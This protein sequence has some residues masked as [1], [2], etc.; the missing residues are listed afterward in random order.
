MIRQCSFFSIGTNDLVQYTLAVDRTNE[1]VASYYVP[2]NPSVLRLI[3]TAARSAREAGKLCAVC[4]ELAGD[5]LF[6][7]FFVGAGIT[8]L[9][10]EAQLIP[11]IKKVIR[12]MTWSESRALSERVLSCSRAGDIRRR[13]AKFNESL[14]MKAD[15]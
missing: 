13:F 2:V 10:M 11:V 8:E 7:P 4:G 9:S 1:S 6:T 14:D 15:Q 12:S 5:P 3:E